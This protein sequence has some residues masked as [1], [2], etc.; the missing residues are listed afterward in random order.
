MSTEEFTNKWR[1]AVGDVPGVEHMTFAADV[2]GPG[3]RGRPVAIELSHR[4]IGVLASASNELAADLGTYPKVKDVNDG[5][6]P[7]KQQLDFTVRPEGKRL[8]L[9]AREVARQVRNAYYGAEALRQQRGRNEI[10]VMVRLPEA[11]RSSEQTI[12]DLMIRTPTGTDV[13]L[14]EVAEMERGRAYTTI[15]R[16]EGR[17][18]VTVSADVTPRNEAGQVLSDLQTEALP[19]LVEKYPGLQYS[20]EGHQAEMRES[21]GSLMV[22]VPIAMA[23]IFV[24]LAIPFRS[25]SQPL[26][27][28]VS[29]P[30]GIVGAIVGHLIMGYS[31]SIMSMFGIVA[32]SGVVVNDSLILIDFAN[33]R[34]KRHG[35]SQHDA[36]VAAG[37]QRFRPI[38]LTTLTTFGGLSPMIFETSRQARF[39]IPMAL[40]LGF[41][42][43]FAT[44]ITLVIVPSLYLAVEDIKR[45]LAR[46]WQFIWAPPLDGK[47]EV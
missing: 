38:I 1:K 20:F 44:L 14:K 16:R 41:G 25:Y 11:E 46:T 29:I 12:E 5:F 32:L 30:F 40:S 35:D 8:G 45:G 24:L 23:V 47:G 36:I 31:L 19:T 4:D 33:R 37:A 34:Q 17:R 28:M 39:L 22:T 3:G 43:V 26:I 7:G 18:V 15:D 27:V 10:K 6:Q 9:S 13:P 42:I 21:L 2:G